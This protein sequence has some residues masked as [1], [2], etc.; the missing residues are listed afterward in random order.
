MSIRG[1]ASSGGAISTAVATAGCPEL[2]VTCTLPAKCE[3]PSAV[4]CEGEMQRERIRRRGEVRLAVGVAEVELTDRAAL[5]AAAEGD[6]V[7]AA[8]VGAHRH[9]VLAG[10]ELVGVVVAV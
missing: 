1:L 8:V 2:L 3:T 9:L 7:Q 6:R 10:V 4:I 5:M